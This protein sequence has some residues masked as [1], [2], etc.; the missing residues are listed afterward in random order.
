MSTRN[1]RGLS[2]PLADVGRRFERWRRRRKVGSRIPDHLWDAAVK[3]ADRCGV[4][5]TARA[6]SID[7][8]TLKNRVQRKPHRRVQ[9]KPHQRVEV[10]PSRATSAGDVPSA[11]LELPPAASG[12]IA[13]CILEL[14][15]ADGAKMRVHVKG[16]EAPDLAALSR[17]FWGSE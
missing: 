1:R 16:V 14:D 2:A 3:A 10:V 15:R 4:A 7:Y 11:F 13:E 17:S 5:H 8:D 6:L 9:S 12:C